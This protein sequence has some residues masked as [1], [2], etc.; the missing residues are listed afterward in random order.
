MSNIVEI[1]PADMIAEVVKCLDVNSAF[2]VQT[3][4]KTF[5]SD[6]VQGIGIQKLKKRFISLFL[7]ITHLA[8]RF[9][10][11]MTSKTNRNYFVL[12]SLNQ[13]LYKFTQQPSDIITSLSFFV[14]QMVGFVHNHT[15]MPVADIF[16]TWNQLVLLLSVGKTSYEIT[17]D[18]EYM[19]QFF[20]EFIIG[21]KRRFIFR[22][23][24]HKI[25][26]DYD[27]LTRLKEQGQLTFAK[28]CCSHKYSLTIMI[29]YTD[30]PLLRFR[31]EEMATTEKNKDV[32]AYL[33]KKVASCYLDEEDYIVYPVRKINHI[34]D[35]LYHV[36]GNEFFTACGM[37][38]LE[39][40]S[41]E[42]FFTKHANTPLRVNGD[43]NCLNNTI[44]RSRA[45]LFDDGT[46]IYNYFLNPVYQ[47]WLT[48]IS[49]TH[50]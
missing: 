48:E 27:E 8:N 31:M 21:V 4:C 20:K 33:Q 49:E 6:A 44:M 34:A 39:R 19:F 24:S 41:V 26:P 30:K 9:D 47:K 5:N 7:N 32:L 22:L 36:Y 1:L 28:A 10:T 40:I 14:E 25:T 2:K 12:I 18:L 38:M 43:Y 29:E 15:H 17:P 42:R 45:S 37:H 3:T 11:I 16:E 50:L 23:N 35:A 46:D 13:V